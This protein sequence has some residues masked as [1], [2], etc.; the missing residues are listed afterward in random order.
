[1]LNASSSHFDPF[2]FSSQNPHC[3]GA[4][5]APEW[6]IAVRLSA[7]DARH[8]PR[9]CRDSKATHCDKDFST[10]STERVDRA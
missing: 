8:Q 3:N 9:S 7:R 4:Q 6:H 5:C 1:M 10:L 2:W